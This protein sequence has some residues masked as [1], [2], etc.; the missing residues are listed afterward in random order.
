MIRH[1]TCRKTER[2]KEVRTKGRARL[3]GKRKKG[4][5]VGGQEVEN[6]ELEKRQDERGGKSHP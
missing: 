5:R 2:E 6:K 4:G 3:N 1:N